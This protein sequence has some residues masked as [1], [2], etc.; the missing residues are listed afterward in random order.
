[1]IPEKRIHS[2]EDLRRFLASP[3][4]RALW[5]FLLL[6]NQAVEGRVSMELEED[7]RLSPFVCGVA[8]LLAEVESWI[9]EDRP[10][11]N[12]GRFGHPAYRNF[13]DKLRARV[14]QRLRPHFGG[15]GEEV[16][17]EEVSAYF[18]D[19][20][21]NR[22]RIDYGTGHE[23][24]FLVFLFCVA[25]IRHI[26]PEDYP[27]VVLF[28]FPRYLGVT[29]ELQRTFNLEPAGSHGAW[30]LDDYS[31]L[32][33]LFGSSQLKGQ[34]RL[35]PVAVLNPSTALQERDHYLYCG[36]IAYIN[37]VKRGPFHEHSPTLYNISGAKGGW[38]KINEGMVKMYRAEVWSKRPVVQHMLF[39]SIFTYDG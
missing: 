19:A 1:M 31:F 35:D 7:N 11:T 38:T 17:L 28:V 18:C 5:D 29:R 30:G 21:G 8:N 34:S 2:E 16:W 27:A 13:V 22:E 23:A 4:F 25:K 36:A 24:S 39:G 9:E 37:E 15:E 20:F 32:P 3:S 26:G 33:F 12:T 14:S 6:L 10:D